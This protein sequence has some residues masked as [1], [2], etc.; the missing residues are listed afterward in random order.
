MNK[1]TIQADEGSV[2]LFTERGNVSNRRN[3]VIAAGDDVL[4]ES[5]NNVINNGTIEG[6]PVPGREDGKITADVKLVAENDIRGNGVTR[7]DKVVLKAKN[8]DI[9]GEEAT[10]NTEA[11]KLRITAKNG[12]ANVSELDGVKLRKSTVEGALTLV[13]QNEGDI[14]VVGEVVANDLDITNNAGDILANNTLLGQNSVNLTALDGNLSGPSLVSG[15]TM[16]LFA[17]NNINL[18]TN[19]SFLSGQAG[20]DLIVTDANSVIIDS[21]VAGNTLIFSNN[22]QF[23]G[24]FDPIS[25]NGSVLAGVLQGNQVLLNIEGNLLDNNGDALNLIANS[26][27]QIFTGGVIGTLGNPFDVLVRNG[28][29]GIAPNGQLNG[30]SAVINGTVNPSN[31]LNLLNNPPGGVLFNGAFLALGPIGDA[32]FRQGQPA[33]VSDYNRLRDLF[34]DSV[35]SVDGVITDDATTATEARIIDER[36]N[37]GQPFD[38]RLIEDDT[39]DGGFSF[40]A[41][42]EDV[43]PVE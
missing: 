1:G 3:G 32:I 13:S 29:L 14:D 25:G 34:A 26:N 31:T 27:S 36:T 9:G 20:N 18:N 43:T 15:E 39:E 12:S 8:G 37:F 4:V 2:G 42:E 10:F 40:V 30:F 17:S 33:L 21:L 7:G 11:N 16:T 35:N 24:I 41:I 5:A 38:L 28:T 6:L 23:P 19:A 22:N